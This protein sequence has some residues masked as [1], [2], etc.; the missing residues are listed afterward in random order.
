MIIKYSVSNWKSF[1]DPTTL[2]LIPTREK[3]HSNHIAVCDDTDVKVLQTAAVYGA[4]AAGKTNFIESLE[5]LQKFILKYYS[6]NN[7]F[8]LQP[9]R[10]NKVKEK[11][12][13][14]F[15]LTILVDKRVY[16]YRLMI[17]S[18]EVIEEEL[19]ERA[20]IGTKTNERL[21]FHRFNRNQY[22]FD[23]SFFSDSEL[24]I[25]KLA[26]EAT[27]SDS[28][29]I[30]TA[31]S[32]NIKSLQPFFDWFRNKLLLIGPQSKY[33][34]LQNYCSSN[35]E[36]ALLKQLDVGI[37][38]FKEV[39]LGPDF[40]HG[41][42]LAMIKNYLAQ[43]GRPIRD[44]DM[45]Y[46]L[47]NGELKASK[48]QSIHIDEDG[49]ER[50]FKITDESDG[51]QRLVDLVPLF[52]SLYKVGAASVVVVDDLDRSIHPFLIRR[53]IQRYLDS[54]S[55]D[56]RAQLVFTTHNLDLF[57]QSLFRRD[58]L[59]IVD[60]RNLRSEL[61]PLADF[62]DIRKDKDVRRS[63]SKGLLGGVPDLGF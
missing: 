25:L 48:I 49:E 51:T 44:E 20:K 37:E 62:K 46:S 34:Q 42:K 40:L 54:R 18:S 10:L 4:N 53:L 26:G 6:F 43:T 58:E 32:F 39:S 52:V 19:W 7:I 56:R 5:F 28:S 15:E 12:P 35:E 41:E 13:T 2:N 45:L 11:E 27:R 17:N 36:I 8:G 38:R 57:D 31:V 21:V 55:A 24:K 50:T 30:T 29:L 47:E 23:S 59:M 14:E 63:Y 22:R 61:Y 16:Q 60:R 33:M 3:Q 9:Y 1:A